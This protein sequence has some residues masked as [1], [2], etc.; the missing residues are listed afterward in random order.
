MESRVAPICAAIDV[1]SNT[2]HVVVA[3]CFSDRL[4]VLAEEQALVRIGESVTATGE[5]SPAKAAAAIDTIKKYQAL[6]TQHQAEQIFVVATE[7]IR[8]AHNSADFI[9]QVRQGTELVVR[10][11]SGT[12]EAALTF[13][14]T[15]YLAGSHDQVGVL[16]LG[17]GS[18]ELVFAQNNHISWRTSVSVGSGWLHDRYLSADPPTSDQIAVAE[19]FLQT[20]FRDL[21]IKHPPPIL[22]ATGGSANV[23]FSLTQK[24][25]H[26]QNSQASLSL[27]TVI[28]S[29]ALLSALDAADISAIYAQPIERARLLLAGSLIIKHIMQRLRLPVILVS[30]HGI[31]EGILL[32]YARY[33]KRWLEEL[34]AEEPQA[35]TF[36]QTAQSMLLSRLHTMLACFENVLKHEDIEAVHK[37]RVASRRL[38]ATLD[39]YQ[40]CCEPK[41]FKKVYRQIKETAD[42]LGEARDADVMLQF[43]HKQL[44]DLT[45]S[46]QEGVSW[47]I[48]RLKIYR[49][50]KQQALE[51]F[52]RHLDAEKLERQLK[53]SLQ[54]GGGK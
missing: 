47:L 29:Q 37:M 17:G 23:L 43:L 9:A 52:L 5:I 19:T 49:Q 32:A 16:D 38:R 54:E 20:Y 50:L 27:E 8:Q 41:L 22:I 30:P 13:L 25:F 3:R 39:A 35:E 34:Q 40:S 21:A 53:A 6:A 12:D 26:S 46:E 48:T 18:L 28:R 36:A 31:R 2:I 44:H 1:G 7:A 33:G 15:T 45:E 51:V 4:D 24:A 10:L 14:G 42:V 11:I